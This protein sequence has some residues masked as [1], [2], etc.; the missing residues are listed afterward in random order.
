VGAYDIY[1]I[2]HDAKILSSPLYKFCTEKFGS[3][4]YIIDFKERSLA[5]M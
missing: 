1:S 5:A 4:A 2:A 3:N